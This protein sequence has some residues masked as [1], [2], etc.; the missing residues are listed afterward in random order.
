MQWIWDYIQLVT[1]HDSR[2][3]YVFEGINEGVTCGSIIIQVFFF[4]FLNM[5]ITHSNHKQG[6]KLSGMESF[7]VSF[8]LQVLLT[9][10]ISEGRL[11]NKREIQWQSQYISLTLLKLVGRIIPL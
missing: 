7:L 4:L 3:R 5:C 2:T 6:I 10:H 1:I 9:N 8:I 11:G